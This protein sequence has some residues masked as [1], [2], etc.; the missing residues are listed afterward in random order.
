MFSLETSGCSIASGSTD[1]DTGVDIVLA[2]VMGFSV[3]GL[4][5]SVV[6]NVLFFMKLKQS[7]CFVT[8]M[9]MY[10]N[11][12]CNCRPD[13]SQ[14]SMK[15]SVV[16]QSMLVR[17]PL[18]DPISNEHVELSELEYDDIRNVTLGNNISVGDNPAYTMSDDDV[19]IPAYINDDRMEANPAD[20]ASN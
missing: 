7:R 9:Y 16:N 3:L 12:Y 6:I 2:I 11:N 18:A 20:Q 14:S 8:S 5:I 19:T 10:S 1:D 15:H 4:M 17:N 13:V